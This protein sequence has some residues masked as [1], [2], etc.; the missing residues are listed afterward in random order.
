M[1]ADFFHAKRGLA[2][3][4]NGY[5]ILSE[6]EIA[7]RKLPPEAFTPILPSPR[8]LS[9]DEVK[10][11][12]DGTPDIERRLFLLDVRLS[13][14][15]IEKRFQSIYKETHVELLITKYA[16]HRVSLMGEVKTTARNDSCRSSVRSCSKM[17]GAGR[18]TCIGSG[19]ACP[20]R[21]R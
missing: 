4:D 21:T 1:L 15:D 13:E 20:L 14:E 16:G 3:G 7:A 5:F 6:E 18:S 9:C 19:T 17:P 2:T 10:A 8:Y 12:P 11:R